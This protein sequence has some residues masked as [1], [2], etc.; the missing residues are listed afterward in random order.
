MTDP[1]HLDPVAAIDRLRAAFRGPA[2]HRSLHAKG[3]FYAGTFTPTAEAGA[4]GRARHLHEPTPV[5]VRWSNAGGNASVPDR[6]PD[7]R[8]MAVKFRL[9]DGTATD[10]LGQTS[11]RFPTDD[12]EE[13]VAMTE[14]SVR[15]LTFPLFLARHPR[16]VPAIVAGV[17]GKAISTPV[18]FAE[19][20]FYPIHAYGWLDGED[21]RT[22][23]RYTFVPLATRADRL[24]RRFSGAD[25]LFEEMAA[26]LARGPVTHEVRVQVAAA[27]DDPH[28]A[29]SVWK[30]ARE[31]V[32]G[33]IVV[34]EALADQEAGGPVVFD[35][36]RVV[37]GI[38]L[39]DDPILRYRP[40]AYTESVSR[41]S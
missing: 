39:S 9:S 36:T 34:S 10:L 35:P 2:A 32:A 12:P 30:G 19:T 38:E 7:I 29:T 6:T 3:R 14:A 18:S 22:W 25:A 23:V 24:E 31:I 28:S 4:L 1:T 13:F 40:V 26:R 20:T 11:P 5:L 37:D 16:M 8:G 41:R 21:R 33:R 17:R 15:K 27:G